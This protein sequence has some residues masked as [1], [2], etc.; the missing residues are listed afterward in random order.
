M[1]K[2]GS[3]LPDWS[4]PWFDCNMQLLFPALFYVHKNLRYIFRIICRP[5]H[6]RFLLPAPLPLWKVNHFRIVKVLLCGF[7]LAGWNV[8][9]EEL[10]LPIPFS[11]ET[12][13]RNILTN[14]ILNLT[15]AF[16]CLLERHLGLG[17]NSISKQQT[18]ANGYVQYLGI[19]SIG[20]YFTI[21]DF[22]YVF[23]CSTCSSEMIVSPFDFE[24]ATTVGLASHMSPIPIAIRGCLRDYLLCQ[25]LLCGFTK[26]IQ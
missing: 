12:A 19:E 15:Y 25:E 21:C 7:F 22:G 26:R 9:T 13:F 14:I 1:T 23:S 18:L 8:P 17:S 20:W 24:M 2:W 11:W 10:F 16:P 4:L 5:F 3:L 6:Q